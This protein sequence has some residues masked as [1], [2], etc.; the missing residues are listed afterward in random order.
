M[1]VRQILSYWK[2]VPY[3]PWFY[4]GN[5]PK[6][7]KKSEKVKSFNSFRQKVQKMGGD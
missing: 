5:N 4:N 1:T 6:E 3:K 2:P 7:L